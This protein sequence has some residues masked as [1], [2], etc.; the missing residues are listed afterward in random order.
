[1]TPRF[2]IVSIAILLLSFICFSGVAQAGLM[3]ADLSAI[4]DS[5]CPSE[6]KQNTDKPVAPCTSPE[7]LCLGCSAALIQ[8]P[9]N[10]TK[11]VDESVISLS[12]YPDIL[13]SG[14]ITRIDYPPESA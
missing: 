4:E 8:I 9:F 2:P 7:C 11:T 13:S 3:L 10:M 12:R 14:F 5:C 1:M 6:D